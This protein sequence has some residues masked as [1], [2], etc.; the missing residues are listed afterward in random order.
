MKIPSNHQEIMPYLILPSAE[1]FVNF[2]QQVFNAELTH[3]GFSP[4]SKIVMHAEIQVEGCTIMFCDATGQWKCQPANMFIYVN[5]A[6]ETYRNALS[7]GAESIMEPADQSYG[8]SCGVK[9]PP[10]QYMVDHLIAIAP[11]YATNT[12]YF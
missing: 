12:D 6:D 10:R 4:D 2:M 9:D 7:N 1:D 11:V 5:N 8:R 3:K